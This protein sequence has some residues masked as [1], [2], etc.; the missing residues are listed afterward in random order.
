MIYVKVNDTLYPAVVEG[1][2]QDTTWDGRETK[3]IT[4]AMDFDTMDAM[5]V[6]GCSWSIVTVDEATAVDD[7]GDETAEE[8]TTEFDNREFCIRGDLTKHT[9][10][11]CTVK[12]GKPTDLEDAYEMIYGGI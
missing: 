5:F 8:R 6:D 10:G 7:A 3:Q 9:D 2:M 4:S 11:T 12:M 1:R